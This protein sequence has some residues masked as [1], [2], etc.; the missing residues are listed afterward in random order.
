MNSCFFDLLDHKILDF[1]EQLKEI[2]QFLHYLSTHVLRL[3]RLS[4]AQFTDFLEKLL[5]GLD[6]FVSFMHCHFTFFADYFL[7]LLIKTHWCYCFLI[8]NWTSNGGY[9]LLHLF[10]WLKLAFG[11]HFL[12]NYIYI[13]SSIWQLIYLWKYYGFQDP[14][15]NVFM[16]ICIFPVSPPFIYFFFLLRKLITYLS[17]I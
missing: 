6:F 16:I 4:L 3:L 14:I 10:Q 9:V 8:M 17:S 11:F 13:K 1:S 5:N 12:L 2:V 15:G 7:T